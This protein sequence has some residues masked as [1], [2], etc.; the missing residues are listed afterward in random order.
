M[1]CV[2]AVRPFR[3]KVG[4]GAVEVRDVVSDLALECLLGKEPEPR[5]E[6]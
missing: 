2:A 6:R 5:H 4:K 3:I 1:S